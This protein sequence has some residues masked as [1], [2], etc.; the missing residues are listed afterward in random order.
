MKAADGSAKPVNGADTVAY[1]EKEKIVLE[2]STALR[3]CVGAIIL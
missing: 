3:G 2:G 1:E